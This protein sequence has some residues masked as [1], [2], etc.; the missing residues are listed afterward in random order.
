[1][2]FTGKIILAPL[3][4]V[5]DPVFRRICREH[6]ADLVVSEMVSAEGVVHGATATKELMRIGSAE[7]PVGI[8]LF[9]CNPDHLAQAATYAEER[10]KP[11][12]IDLNAGCPVRKVVQKNGGA[13][14]LRNRDLF[15]RIVAAMVKAVGATPITV[16]IRS[17]WTASEWI[18]VEFARI[19]QDAGAAA[20]T[21]HPRSKSMGFAGQAQWDRIAAVKAAVRIPVIGNGDI[22]TPADAREMMDQTGCDSV[23]IGRGSFGN[24]WL[25]GQCRAAIEGRPVE[26][27]TKS[28]RYATAVRH[29]ALFREWYGEEHAAREMKKHCA[30]Y[31]KGLPGAAGLRNDLFK[32]KSTSQ[33][34]EIL[35]N[36]FELQKQEYAIA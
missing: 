33:L 18:D 8:Q 6:G 30:W 26:R 7:R 27:T 32:A 17:G 5:S 9:G 16:K 36:Y 14:L 23:M 21:L 34:E 25:F 22:V 24:P 19:A 31:I 4:G 2:D 11:D 35:S 3:A 20:V 13:A 15:G 12:F 10:V 29:I 1:V 28:Q